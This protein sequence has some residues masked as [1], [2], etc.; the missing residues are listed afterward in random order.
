MFKKEIATFQYIIIGV[1]IILIGF[2]TVHSAISQTVLST[3]TKVSSGPDEAAEKPVA[4]AGPVDEYDRGSPRSSLKGY[5]I[6]TRDGDY[7]RAGEY[8]D[9]RDLPGW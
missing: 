3:V 8:L 4:P 1:S 6:A 5:F 7:K 2:F 9:M